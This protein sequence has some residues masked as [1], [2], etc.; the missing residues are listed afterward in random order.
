MVSRVV[1]LESITANQENPGKGRVHCKPPGLEK[2]DGKDLDTYGCIKQ[3][4][5]AVGYDDCKPSQGE[6][7]IIETG[8]KR[9]IMMNFV[10]TGDLPH[11]E[12]HVGDT[13]LTHC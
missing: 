2:L 9:W 3:P 7:E 10:N 5:G 13:T 11:S 8:Y 6:Y 4:T 1:L 12:E